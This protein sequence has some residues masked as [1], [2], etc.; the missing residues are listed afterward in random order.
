MQKRKSTY[1]EVVEFRDS[2]VEQQHTRL[3]MHMRKLRNEMSREHKVS[4]HII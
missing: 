3:E 4:I 2:I 1:D